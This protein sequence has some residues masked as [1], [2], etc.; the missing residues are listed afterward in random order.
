MILIESSFT[1]LSAAYSVVVLPEPVGP[2]TT[3]MPL[4]IWMISLNWV[5]SS[6]GKPTLSRSRLTTLRSRIRITTDS[7]NMVGS[8]LTRRS[9]SRSPMRTEILPSCG[10]RRSAMSRWAMT[11]MRATSGPERFLGT[12]SIS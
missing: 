7:P 9:T 8:V 5:S 1:A 10:M 12:G 11:L 4:G 2:V 3:T 6:S